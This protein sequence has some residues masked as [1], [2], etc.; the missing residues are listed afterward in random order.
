M[1]INKLANLQKYEWSMRSEAIEVVLYSLVG[2]FLPFMLA[3]PQWLV[4]TIVN[5]M[6]ISAA[7]SVRGC[8]LLPVIML[9]SIG[10]LSAGLIFG[11][12]TPFLLYMIAFI[13][14]GNSLLVGAFKFLNIHKKWNYFSTLVIGAAVKSLFLFIA[15]FVLFK[16]GLVPVIFLTAMGIMQLVTVMTGGALAFGFEKAKSYFG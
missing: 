6:L 11:K 2:F 4:G 13:W 15:A 12:F 9:P 16:F 3:H 1:Y 14:I 5:A 10:I 8:K 7:M